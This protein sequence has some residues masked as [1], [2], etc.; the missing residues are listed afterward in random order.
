[1]KSSLS[2]NSI[3][4]CYLEKDVAFVVDG[5]ARSGTTLLSAALNSQTGFCVLRGAMHEPLA[6]DFGKWPNGYLKSDLTRAR[7]LRLEGGSYE[8]TPDFFSKLSEGL[9]ETYAK[10]GDVRLLSLAER[11]AEKRPACFIDLDSIY[12]HYEVDIDCQLGL[13]W[14]QGLTFHHLWTGRGHKWIWV[15]RDPLAR[16]ASDKLTFLR[17]IRK[18]LKWTRIY[19]ECIQKTSNDNDFYLVVHYED[20][21]LDMERE[22]SRIANFLGTEEHKVN[23]SIVD[24]LGRPF[25][26]NSS[27][28]ILKGIDHRSYDEQG[29]IGVDQGLIKEKMNMSRWRPVFR[30]QL[31]DFPVYERYM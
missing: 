15:V 8:P 10:T 11:V 1:M 2:D 22:I 16:A 31:R 12:H 3:S 13:R 7:N 5:L 30:S 4:I 6:A 26:A 21:V 24:E 20:L 19:G 14:N 23:R 29:S 28:K 18:S 9:H 25:Q 17:P 27:A